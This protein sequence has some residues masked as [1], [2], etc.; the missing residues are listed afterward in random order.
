M[1][2]MNYHVDLFLL[3]KKKKKTHWVSKVKFLWS[4]CF[5]VGRLVTFRQVI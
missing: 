3:K 4:F 5:V 1:I 2:T